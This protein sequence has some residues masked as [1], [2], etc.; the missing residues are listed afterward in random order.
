MRAQA[1]KEE[2]VIGTVPAE[3]G[4]PYVTMAPHGEA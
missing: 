1:H 4:N 3:R 2:M